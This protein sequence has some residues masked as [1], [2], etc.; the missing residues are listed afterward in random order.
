MSTAA[1]EVLFETLGAF[2]KSG[3]T[4]AFDPNLR[5]KLWESADSMVQTISQFGL[6]SDLGL[7]SFE[8]DANWFGDGSPADCAK[9]YQ[10][11]GVSEVIVKNGSG[12]MVLLDR[13]GLITVPTNKCD[14]V[15]DTTAAGDSFNAGF[16]AAREMGM[17]NVEAAKFGAS[18]AAQVIS[19]NSALIDLDFHTLG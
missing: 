15:V 1:R 19:A 9:R 18:V 8:D 7:P 14:A 11:S 5:P 3:G 2:K 17:S 10:A 4:V 6:I 16:F 12:D 13:N